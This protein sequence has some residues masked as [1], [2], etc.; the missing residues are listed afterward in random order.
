MLCVKHE[1]CLRKFERSRRVGGYGEIELNEGIRELMG[2][3]CGETF[4]AWFSVFLCVW[5]FEEHQ[6]DFMIFEIII[7]IKIGGVCIR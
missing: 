5:M 2:R 6:W 1:G 7:C 4:V 3:V